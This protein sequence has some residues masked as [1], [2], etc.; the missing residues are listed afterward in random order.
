MIDDKGLLVWLKPSRR[1]TVRK[2]R[3]EVEGTLTI[4]SA[5]YFLQEIRPIFNKYDYVD[6]YLNQVESID[7]SFI[8]SLYHLK[9]YYARQEKVVTVDAQLDDDLK[10]IITQSGFERLI[11]KKKNV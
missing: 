4:N 2:T 6:F 5:R 9:T 7:L 10:K 1:K 11:L 3:V 8:Q